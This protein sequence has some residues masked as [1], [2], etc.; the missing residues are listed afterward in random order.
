VKVQQANA[1]VEQYVVKI[2]AKL[3][4]SQASLALSFANSMSMDLDVTLYFSRVLHIAYC[5]GFFQI[6]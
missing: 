4:N 5:N 1:K 6:N 2:L 3:G